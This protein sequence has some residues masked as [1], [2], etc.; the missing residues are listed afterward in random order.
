MALGARLP[1]RQQ[2][3]S[4]PPRRFFSRVVLLLP[5]CATP[6]LG[7]AEV[8]SAVALE[9]QAE[10]LALAPAARFRRKVT[11]LVRLEAAARRSQAPPPPEFAAEEHLRSLSLAGAP[12]RTESARSFF[13]P[14]RAFSALPSSSVGPASCA[15]AGASTATAAELRQL[16]ALRLQR[17]RVG[18]PPRL[19]REASKRGTS[20]NR[21][22]RS[23]PKPRKAAASRKALSSPTPTLAEEA[24]LRVASR[25]LRNAE[26]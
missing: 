7:A 4:R 3:T 2:R 5:T 21:P 15:H 9:L 12:R 13:G 16:P 23:S 10:Q 19:P 18:R 22:G 24:K 11:L 8:R 25:P 20:P 6:G 14:G 26:R 17:P 1:P